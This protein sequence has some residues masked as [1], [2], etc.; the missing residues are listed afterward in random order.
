MAICCNKY[1]NDNSV[2]FYDY[3]FQTLR[4]YN[5]QLRYDGINKYIIIGEDNT[6]DYQLNY[7]D[8][9]LI[10]QCELDRYQPALFDT[11]AFNTRIDASPEALEKPIMQYLAVD[12]AD[13]DGA[14]TLIDQRN[15]QLDS[16]GYEVRVVTYGVTELLQNISQNM[17]LSISS[18]SDI[19]KYIP[20]PLIGKTVKP[21]YFSCSITKDVEIN[22]IG[23]FKQDACDSRL[24][25]RIKTKIKFLDISC[26][27]TSYPECQML[28][29]PINV[30]GVVK[31]QQADDKYE[32]YINNIDAAMKS[33]EFSY[34][35]EIP[36]LFD[37]DNKPLQI[38]AYLPS[39]YSDQ[40]YH[41][42]ANG[43]NVNLSLW[44]EK[45]TITGALTL[46]ID[47]G[48]INQDE[49]ANMINFGKERNSW[50]KSCDKSN[51]IELELNNANGENKQ[52][53]R[54]TDQGLSLVLQA[55]E[56]KVSYGKILA[57][58]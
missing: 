23:F 40:V 56:V 46:S 3:L 19:E 21:C 2:S 16:C 25:Y 51:K 27:Y 38:A 22:Q 48:L 44:R 34:T 30:Q 10:E 31:K 20:K 6:K 18:N 29:Y 32:Y 42:Y 24:N 39:L 52:S 12:H 54:F 26:D 5:L 45:A 49:Q 8:G 17:G 53:V 36:Y 55:V 4:Y 11:K 50:I 57:F 47:P 13:I 9:M 33:G 15:K 35:V 1:G 41:P 58:N 28:D 43:V 37:E 7:I 14:A